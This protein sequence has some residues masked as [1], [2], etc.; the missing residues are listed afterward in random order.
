MRGVDSDVSWVGF[1][2]CLSQV[3]AVRTLPATFLIAAL[4]WAGLLS[5]CRTTSIQAPDWAFGLNLGDV[6]DKSTAQ[7]MDALI[8]GR[9]LYR[10]RP[11]SPHRAM[12]DYALVAD[13][14]SGRIV[15]IVGWDRYSGDAA[16]QAQRAELGQALE[17][18]Y[19]PGKPVQPADRER[20]RG[21]P[22]GLSTADLTVYP[23]WQ[24]PVALGC[25]GSRLL[26]AY[27]FTPPAPA[28]P[29]VPAEPAAPAGPPA[30]AP[31]VPPSAAPAQSN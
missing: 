23:G 11:P 14:Q 2:H 29:A 18:R 13:Q 25:A 6:L 22:E 24:G 10:V 30:A 31:S 5:A 28:E 15:G 26:L 19:G 27:W 20:M 7:P 12:S 17:R 16:C 21:L 8:A 9:A 1:P 4:L 3:A